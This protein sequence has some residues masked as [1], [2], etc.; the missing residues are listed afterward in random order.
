[1]SSCIRLASGKLFDILNPEMAL[2]TPEVIAHSLSNQCRFAGHTKRFY[3]VAEHCVR[4]SYVCEDPLDFLLHDASEAFVID[5]PTPLKRL[6]G[7]AY[8]D[9]EDR[10]HRCIE[11]RYGV[12]IIDNEAVHHTDKVMLATEQTEL[13]LDAEFDNELALQGLDLASCSG[14]PETWER[15]WL[16]RFYALIGSAAPHLPCRRPPIMTLSESF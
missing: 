7:Q 9:I 15:R 8:T 6:L 5:V 14:R 10:I 1:V 12:S 4:G 13:V 11:R 3:S 16:E 2:M